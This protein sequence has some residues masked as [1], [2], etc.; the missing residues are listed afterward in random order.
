MFFHSFLIKFISFALDDVKGVFRA[1]ADAGAQAVAEIVRHHFGLAV[2][3]PDGAFGAGDNA[4]AA[5]GAA[6]FI[7]L[8]D[9]SFHFHGI[10]SYNHGFNRLFF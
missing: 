2:N 6:F 9:L 1:L 4:L 10:P 8:Y 5:A 7:Y 3:D